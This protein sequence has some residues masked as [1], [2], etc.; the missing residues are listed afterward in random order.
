MLFCQQGTRV[1]EVNP[2]ASIVGAGGDKPCLFHIE[3]KAL[4]CGVPSDVAADERGAAPVARVLGVLDEAGEGG[5]SDGGVGRGRVAHVLC[6]SV[7]WLHQRSPL[8][9]TVGGCAR[10]GR[11]SPLPRTRR[12][13]RGR[14]CGMR[15]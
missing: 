10:G 5:G 11:V 2:D 6:S 4:V 13:H 14:R 8:G 3:H 1:R 9:R 7:G 12:G 15:G